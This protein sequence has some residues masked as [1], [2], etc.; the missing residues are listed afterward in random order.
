MEV[1]LN[2]ALQM[3]SCLSYFV[4]TYPNL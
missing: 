1:V 2:D 4:K 3:K